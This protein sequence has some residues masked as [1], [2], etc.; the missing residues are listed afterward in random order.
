[1][2]R[3]PHAL[4][5]WLLVLQMAAASGFGIPP[6]RAEVSGVSLAGQWAVELDPQDRGLSGNWS[7]RPL[8]GKIRLPST[9][10]LA[11]LGEKTEGI[12]GGYLSRVYKYVGPAWY[13][14]DIEIP[15]AWSGR[16]VELFLERVLWQSTVFV[17][18]RRVGSEDSL[19]TPHLH[20]L[21]VLAPG[22]HHLAVRVD[23]RMIHPL[24]DKGHCY[25]EHTQ[26][27]WNGIVG[28]IELRARGPV[29]FGL[30]RT[31]PDASAKKVTVEAVLRNTTGQSQSGTLSFLV[32]RAGGKK[33]TEVSV[34]FRVAGEIETAKITVPFPSAPELWSEFSRPLYSL[35][36]R[37]NCSVGR[38]Q[39]PARTFG[40]RTLG[41]SGQHFA[42][43]GIP[44]FMRGNLESAVFPLTGH[45]PCDVESWRRIFQVYRE[46]GLNQ[47]RFHSWCPPEA[48][49]QAADELGIYLHAEVL[50]IDGWMSGPNPRKDMETPGYPQ[51]V[52]KGDRTIDE[53][54]RA[55]TRRMLDAYG[56][57]PSFAFFIFGNELGNSDFEVMGRWIKEYK[58]YD[59]RHY[60][61][62]SSARTITPWDDFQDTHNI[63]GVGG[64]VNAL[65]RPNTDWDY[66][67]SFSR[68]PV[69]II[70][71]ELGQTPVYPRWNEIAKYTG[72]VRARN[73]ESFRAAA[74]TNGIDRQDA[75]FQAASGRM[76][77]II[78]KDE[79]EAHFRTPSCSGINLLSM[80]DY[81]G[82]GEALVGWLDPFYVSKGF[83]T[84]KEFRQYCDTTVPLAR[85]ARYVWTADET[86]AASAEVAHYG[87]KP[88]RDMAATW[89]LL[90]QKGH[91]LARGTFPSTN[92]NLGT[93]TR[94]GQIE[95]PLASVAA[96]Q[97]LTLEIVL[98]GTRFRNSWNLWVFPRQPATSTPDDVLVTED[99]DVALA[100]LGRGGKVLLLAHHLGEKRNAGLAAFMP[101]FWSATFFPG[102]A[103]ET[104]GAVVHSRHP[105][106]KHFPT[107]NTLDWQWQDLCAGARGF[108]LDPLPKDYSPIVQ[109]VHDFHYQHKLGS[110]FELKTAAGGRLLVCGYNLADRLDQ[111]PAA[112]QLLSSLLSYM[113]GDSFRPTTAVDE[114][115]LRQILPVVKQA[116]VVAPAGFDGA[117][118]Y[119][120]CAGR[121]PGQ[122]N[123]AW[124][125]DYDLIKVQEAGY[126]YQ[127]R[128][129]GI[130]RDE[131]G[132][133]WFGKRIRVDIRMPTASLADL[134]VRCHDW[135][136]N[137]RSANLYVEGR[138][139]A[140]ASHTEGKWVKLDVLRE[141]ANDGTLTFEAECTSGPNIQITDLALVPRK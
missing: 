141:D 70:A 84:A 54:V 39:A 19:G 10:D 56:D 137:G 139:V 135:N 43:N 99:L 92:F 72:P 93:I 12:E 68:G 46:H 41:R 29:N 100:A 131:V 80:Q 34:P 120:G 23:N 81:T 140:L 98:P 40:F 52:G 6:A 9:T 18:G 30:V 117:V 37:L 138:K 2:K 85:F 44:T 111:R 71:H 35:E 11:G 49:F 116:N 125:K 122:G 32:R 75:G 7:E 33:V 58:E 51:G 59:P 20:P 103:T 45:P 128:C 102:Q 106:L 76:N 119:V 95:V 69:P 21:G 22:R 97:R 118:L 27:I 113:A 127:V 38:D 1:M 36:S 50:W 57:H 66:E 104:L 53:Y 87:Q 8:A 73:L 89:K 133:A 136:N 107:G 134:Y 94:L 86:F 62:A 17:D 3:L 5:G 121:H 24:S 115:Q 129:D 123:A 78:Y 74:K 63:P 16:P 91:P 67:K 42:V 105:A 90:D 108:L 61:A 109:P 110:I 25:T 48:A 88:I 79:I 124:R 14:R 65:G 112:R 77:Q 60:Y 101:L 31:F 13:A 114:A 15:A 96:P 47:A 82:Q 83:L 64:T 132:S 130:W 126:D 4:G 26:T 55:E 28:R